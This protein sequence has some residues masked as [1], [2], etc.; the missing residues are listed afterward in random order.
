MNNALGG[1]NKVYGVAQEDI[2]E[3]AE[4]VTLALNDLS[5]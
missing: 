2:Q 3:F 4:V 1:M 5:R